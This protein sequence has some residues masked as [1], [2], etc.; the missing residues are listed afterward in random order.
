MIN[1]T[2][3]YQKQRRWDDAKE[4]QM[5][6]LEISKRIFESNHSVII[7]RINDRALNHTWI[8]TANVINSWNDDDVLLLSS[9]TDDSTLKFSQDDDREI[10][11]EFITLLINDKTLKALFQVT[12]E[13]IDAQRFCRNAAKILKDFVRNLRQEANSELQ[14]TS[15]KLVRSRTQYIVSWISQNL[16]SNRNQFTVH[17][18]MNDLST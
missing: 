12:L 3:N 15:V 9:L 17:R 13:K 1:L 7:F 14:Q 2:E 4:L 5:Q 18:K 8:S 11:K 10:A 16:N 6:V